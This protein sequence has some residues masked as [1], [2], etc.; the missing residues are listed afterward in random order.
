MEP[1]WNVCAR[2]DLATIG[3]EQVWSKAKY[4][5][6]CQVDRY[7]AMNLQFSHIH[8]VQDIMGQITDDFAKRLAA[9]S[10]PAVMAA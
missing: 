5:Y 10:V 1:I 4:L 8:L 9:H 7:K 3:I 2:P 6:R